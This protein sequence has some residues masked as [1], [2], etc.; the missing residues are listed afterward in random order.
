MDQPIPPPADPLTELLC[1]LLPEQW[2]HD[3]TVTRYLLGFA[4]HFR[5][6]A[7]H[8]HTLEARAAHPDD[9]ALVVGPTL[10]Y[11]YTQVEEALDL[12][13]M[14]EEYRAALTTIAAREA[15]ILPRLEAPTGAQPVGEMALPRPHSAGDDLVTLLRETLPEGW[16]HDVAVIVSKGSMLLT[17]RDA[18]GRQHVLDA[19]PL[20]RD[21]PALVPGQTLGFSYTMVDPSLDGTSL[22]EEYRAVLTA[23]AAREADILPWLTEPP[24]EVA[25][26]DPALGADPIGLPGH[27]DQTMSEGA[28]PARLLPLLPPDWREAVSVALISDGFAVSFADASGHQHMLEARSLDTG[29][30]ALMSGKHF[31]FSYFK[32][33]PKLDE[34]AVVPKYREVLKRFIEQEGQIAEDLRATRAV[35]GKG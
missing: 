32:I 21:T 4:L 9:P 17:C 30:P 22:I 23:M 3:V 29:F 28:L 12:D 15:D 5:D 34:I 1:G 13:V 6:A 7:G 14:L 11:S 33:D 35:S 25:A 2:R 24:A 10:A 18:K 27:R 8:Q 31:G 20:N 16:R 19:R 26:G